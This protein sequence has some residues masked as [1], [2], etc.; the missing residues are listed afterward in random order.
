MYVLGGLQ[1]SLRQ[2]LRSAEFTVPNMAS[3]SPAIHLGL[4]D[5]AFDSHYSPSCL[6]I[7]I[8]ASKTDPSRKGCF[9]YIGKGDFPLC[10]IQ[11]LL[12]YLSVRGNASGPL[13]LFRDSQPLCQAILSPWLRLIL[14]SAGTDGNFSSH[15]FRIVAATVAARNG[16][17]DHQIQVLGRWTSK[18]YLTYI[19]TPA[20]ALS[21]LSKQLTLSAARWSLSAATQLL[22]FTSGFVQL[23]Q[24]WFLSKDFVS[25]WRLDCCLVYGELVPV[26]VPFLVWYV[27]FLSALLDV[28]LRDGAWKVWGLGPSPTLFAG[29]S[30]SKH[31]GGRGLVVAAHRVVMVTR[32]AWLNC[33]W[34]HHSFR[35]LPQAHLLMNLNVAKCNLG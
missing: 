13:F 14:S 5:I 12:A 30:L 9:V 2:F 3:Y 28:G 4:P 29:L 22:W 16:I 8:K 27:L 33:F 10:A 19:R 25:L 7:R 21:K 35:H 20:E 1:F 31:F 23:R 11:S 15:S 26:C 6:S 18:A 24:S 32:H 17:A 34:L